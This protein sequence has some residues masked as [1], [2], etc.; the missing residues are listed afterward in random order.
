M[1]YFEEEKAKRKEQIEKGRDEFEAKQTHEDWLGILDQWNSN[2]VEGVTW[3]D[4]KHV[5]GEM[6][7]TRDLRD[8][9]LEQ[10]EADE[11]EEE[12]ANDGDEQKCS[13]CQELGGCTDDVVNGEV[14]F[15]DHRFTSS[16]LM[17]MLCFRLVE[18][19]SRV[20]SCR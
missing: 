6:D 10:H 20:C 12:A 19:V 2:A 14:S 15:L 3:W 5:E 17:Y 1:A 7:R 13:L 11:R 4:A 18:C 9:A 8:K 16:P